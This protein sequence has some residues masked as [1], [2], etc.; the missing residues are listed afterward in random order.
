MRSG[1]WAVVTTSGSASTH[2]SS[3]DGLAMSASSLLALALVA[4]AACT[5]PPE[6]PPTNA[7]PTDASPSETPPARPDPSAAVPTRLRLAIGNGLDGWTRVEI[8][9]D[10]LVRSQTGPP[11]PTG[12]PAPTRVVPTAAD[13]TAFRAALD[14]AGVWDWQASYVNPNYADGTLWTVEVDY[15]DRTVRA[16]GSNRYPGPRGAPRDAVGGPSYT[17][18][19]DAVLA[20]VRA[21]TGQPFE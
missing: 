15:P 20:A 4:L 2:A 10:T 17:A 13:W 19:F 7:S 6:S 1:A 5:S 11:S 14:G 9:G 8:A 3:A 18:E 12:P 21:L 16:S